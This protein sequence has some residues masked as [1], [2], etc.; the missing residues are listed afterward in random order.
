MTSVEVRA[1]ASL[2]GVFGLRMLGLFFILPVLAVHAANIRGGDDLTLVGVALGAYGLSQ[3]ILQIPFGMASDR[4]GRKPVLYAGLAVFAA[5]SFLGMIAHDIWTMIGARTLQGAGAISSVAMALAADLTRDQH[6]TK[7]MAMI[8]SMIGLM[9]ALSLVG[10]PLLYRAIGMD[11][12]FALTG[13]LCLAAMAVV[14]FQVPDPPAHGRAAPAAGSVRAALLDAELVRLNAGI[15]ILHVVLYAMFVVVP[16]LLVQA[17]LALPEHWKLYLPVVLGSFVLMVPA[18]LYADRRNA[19]KPVLVGAVAL[20]VGAEA[21]F[22]VLGGGIAVLAAVMLGFFVAFNVL[23]ALLPSLVS[24]R[25]PAAGRGAAIGVYNTTQTLGVFF[26]GLLGGWVAS[27]YGTTGVFAACAVLSAVWLVLAAGMRHPP[28][29]NELSSLTF[30]IASGVNLDGLREALARV[31]GVRE[32]EV[33]AAERIAR[34][35]V[36]PGQWDEH[37]VRKL[38][39]GEV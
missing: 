34:L 27:R 21:A 33:V 23:E 1:G 29:V 4:W 19:S 38:I 22:A 39:T 30:P 37:R 13:A 8:G 32:A 28:A 3:G 36:V 7:V 9:F 20:L 14:K 2:A 17:G 35:K 12:L 11:G 15:F 18:V 25:A 26:G 24:R 5:G 10:A 31:K 6:R 16:P